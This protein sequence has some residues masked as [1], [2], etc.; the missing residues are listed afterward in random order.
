MSQDNVALVVSQFEAV[1]AGD[2]SAVTDRWAEDV[3]L[4]A[5]GELAGLVGATGHKVVAGKVAVALW[6]ADW[7][8]QFAHDYRF[9][10]DESRDLGERVIIIAT[11]HGRGRASGV[12]VT[13]QSGYLYTLREGDISR[14]ELWNDR[15]GAFEAAGLTE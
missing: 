3:S 13:I 6:F 14:I 5:H 9:E 15:A 11:H 4:V 7:F 2:F 10:I 1:N 12:P 8:Q